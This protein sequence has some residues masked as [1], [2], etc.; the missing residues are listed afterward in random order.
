M[1]PPAVQSQLRGALQAQL[2]AY[3]ATFPLNV[4]RVTFKPGCMAAIGT[5]R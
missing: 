3:A 5:T 2:D 1:I 4:Q